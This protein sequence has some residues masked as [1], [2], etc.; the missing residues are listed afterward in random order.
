MSIFD[1]YSYI[2]VEKNGDIS[3]IV[4]RQDMIDVGFRTRNP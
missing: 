3:G 4:T 1:L 2:F